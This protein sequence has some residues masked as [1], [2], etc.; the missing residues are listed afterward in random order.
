MYYYE[1]DKSGDLIKFIETLTNMNYSGITISNSKVYCSAENNLVK[2]SEKKGLYKTISKYNEPIKLQ[3][4]FRDGENWI[5]TIKKTKNIE[6]VNLGE[7][8]I[9]NSVICL[10]RGL[11]SHINFKVNK[12]FLN[13]W[14]NLIKI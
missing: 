3:Q 5:K 10:E 6:G 4:T 2:K 14:T 1:Y 11:F 12:S 7:Y 8:V 13:K 9:P